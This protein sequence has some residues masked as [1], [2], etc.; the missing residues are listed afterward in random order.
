MARPR[1]LL[2]WTLLLVGAGSGGVYLADWSL[3]DVTEKFAASGVGRLPVVSRGDPAALLGVVSHSDVLAAHQHAIP[4]RPP[5][6]QD[7]WR[8]RGFS[9]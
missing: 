1:S 7:A 9:P 2:R 6:P 8:P 5:R 3:T 4:K